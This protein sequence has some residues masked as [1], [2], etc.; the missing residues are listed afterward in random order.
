MVSVILTGHKPF[1][2]TGPTTCTWNE[3]QLALLG[4]HSKTLT[5]HRS[6]HSF[7]THVA[8]TLLNTRD[9]NTVIL[10][11]QSE[12]NPQAGKWP[13]AL[14][15]QNK[16]QGSSHDGSQ[17]EPELGRWGGGVGRNWTRVYLRCESAEV[18][19]WSLSLSVECV[20]GP[21]T[22][23]KAVEIVFKLDV[24]E[25]MCVTGRKHSSEELHTVIVRL[26]GGKK[27]ENNA[28]SSLWLIYDKCTN[29]SWRHE[30][31]Y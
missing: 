26:P 3:F 20:G 1:V 24:P 28:A 18:L 21:L 10:L 27:R 23:F 9:V 30:W 15:L 2:N 22:E 16:R 7:A 12:Y 4:F 8:V 17:E 29:G 11:L 6:T 14:E 19:R 31:F 13:E 25:E 5:A